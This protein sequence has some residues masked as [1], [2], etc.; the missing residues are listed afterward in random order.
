MP[1]LGAALALVILP[2][3]AACGSDDPT[4]PDTMTATISGSAW[5]AGRGGGASSPEATLQVATST[6]Q[7]IGTDASGDS[8][9]TLSLV[10]AP[11][12]G[13]GTYALAD[14]STGRYAFLL[15]STGQLGSPGFTI[16]SHWSDGAHVGSLNVTAVDAARLTGTFSVALYSPFAGTRSVTAGS[17]S[18]PLRNLGPG[19]PE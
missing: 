5:R 6:L 12:T 2:L 4:P 17:Y 9:R 19:Q 8:V 13:P 15:T 10:V 14:T 1:R 7:L 18:L 11:Y 3:S 16:V